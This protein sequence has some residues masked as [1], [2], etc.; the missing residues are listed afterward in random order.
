MRPAVPFTENAEAVETVQGP[1]T[2]AVPQPVASDLVNKSLANALTGGW[3][4]V[5]VVLVVLVLVDVDDVEV[6]DDVVVVDDVEVVVLAGGEVV[7][8]DV[9]DVVD[10]VVVAGGA[11]LVIVK[12]SVKLPPAVGT[13]F[14]A[15]CSS[16]TLMSSSP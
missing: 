15:S 8:V 16:L 12:A 13:K 11:P 9:E 6:V 10:V 14:A 2:F 4:V 7:V 1:P 3:V 5:L